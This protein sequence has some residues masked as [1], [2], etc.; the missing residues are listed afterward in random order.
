MYVP[1]INATPYITNALG[2]THIFANR[3]TLDY[4]FEIG[5]AFPPY[6]DFSAPGVG[7]S[8]MAFQYLL[9]AYVKIGGI[10]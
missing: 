2:R 6:N 10:F 7:N 3:I 5:F 8:R 9:N 4:G 1:S